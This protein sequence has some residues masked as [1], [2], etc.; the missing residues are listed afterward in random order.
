MIENE[1]LKVILS[2]DICGESETFDDFYEAVKYKKENG[3]TS[4]REDGEWQDFCPD[5]Q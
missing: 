1:Y 5:C 2:C 3:W 4:R